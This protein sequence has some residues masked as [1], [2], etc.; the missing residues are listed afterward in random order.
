MKGVLLLPEGTITIA[1][2][3][4]WGRFFRL[5]DDDGDGMNTEDDF[6]LEGLAEC[7][8]RQVIVQIKKDQCLDGAYEVI[9][10]DRI[11]DDRSTVPE[12]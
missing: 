12:A 3:V 5:Y 10:L 2:S 4:E 7:T 8:E 9:V 11:D 6:L 1:C